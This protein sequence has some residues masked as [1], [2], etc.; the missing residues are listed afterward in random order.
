MLLDLITYIKL[1]G[2]NLKRLDSNG[3]QTI[4]ISPYNKT[5]WEI[6]AGKLFVG[7]SRMPK[8]YCNISVDILTE[9]DVSIDDLNILERWLK[10]RMFQ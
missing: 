5:T 2:N 7:I 3:K 8:T 1:Y 4:I 10:L 6:T 9:I